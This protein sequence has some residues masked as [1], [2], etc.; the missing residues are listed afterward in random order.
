MSREDYP[1]F[2]HWYKTL[3]CIISVSENFPKKAR[4]SLASRIVDISLGIM[5]SIVEAIYTRERGS[6]LDRINLDMEKLRILVRIAADRR[7]ISMR[8]HEHIA[9]ALHEAG[10]MT[11]GWRKKSREKGQASF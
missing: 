4:F 7:Y 8:Q 9:R 2:V 5:E 11:G 1:L 6:I 10:K 3:D